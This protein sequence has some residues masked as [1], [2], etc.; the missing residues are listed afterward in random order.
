MPPIRHR[1]FRTTLLI[2][3][4]S[5]LVGCKNSERTWSAEAKSPDGKL[6]VTAETLE[7]GGWGT[8]APPETYVD[9]N[10]TSGSQRPTVVFSFN[11]GSNVPVALKVGL[12]WLTARHLELTYDSNATID[13]QAIKWGEVEI[14]ARPGLDG[15]R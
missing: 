10:W 2:F 3:T 1:P 15:Q 11:D 9:L 4:M 6:V 14:S 13:F 7:P 8:S 5:V 12:H